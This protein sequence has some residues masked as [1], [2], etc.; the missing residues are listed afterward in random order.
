MIPAAGEGK[1]LKKNY[2]TSKIYLN[3]IEEPLIIEILNS[4][5]NQ[6]Q[7]DVLILKKDFKPEFFNDKDIKVKKL[8]KKTDGQAESALQLIKGI[9]NNQP[10]LIHSADCVLDKSTFVSIEDADIVAYTKKNYR[11][12]FSQEQ[13]YGWVNL[14]KEK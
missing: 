5:K 8:S 1:D 3:L 9:D 4:F 2:E 7:T 10:V 6:I 12:A 14:E 11:R 13:N